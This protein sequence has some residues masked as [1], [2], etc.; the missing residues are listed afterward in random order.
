[1]QVLDFLQLLIL[2]AFTLHNVKALSPI[3]SY[4]T[5]QRYNRIDFSINKSK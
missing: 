5:K 2:N 4:N 1:M 3:A